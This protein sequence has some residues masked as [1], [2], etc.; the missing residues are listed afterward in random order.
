MRRHYFTVVTLFLSLVLSG[1][2]LANDDFFAKEAVKSL[3]HIEFYKGPRLQI[4]V[5]ARQLSL[6]DHVSKLIKTYPIAVGSS[7]FRTPV[8]PREM[9]QIIWNPWWIP[10]Q[11]E[12]AKNDKPTP[13]G[14]RNPLGPVKMRLGGAILMHGTNKPK[15][16]GNPASHG[17]MRMFSEDAQELA[18]YIQQ[19]VTSKNDL[20]YRQE[21]AEKRNQSFFVNL[22]QKIPVKIIYEVVEMKEGQL[23]VY[24]DVYGKAGDKKWLIEKTF[25]ENGLAIEK[26]YLEPVLAAIK[27][28]QNQ[29]DLVFDVV[30]L[31]SDPELKK[32]YVRELA[33]RSVQIANIF[34]FR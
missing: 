31:I 32:Q 8:G 7:V 23:F 15:S 33:S 16:V 1:I 13:P 26:M 9:D 29:D 5:A 20:Q 17:C 25:R 2:S 18:W 11:S 34:L 4:N 10:P 21:Y 28:S 3:R 30:D 6:Y 27:K 24:R 14:A 12:W 19:R 22:D